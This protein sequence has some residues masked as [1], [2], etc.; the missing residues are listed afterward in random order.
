[1]QVAPFLTNNETV[2]QTLLDRGIRF[3]TPTQF[4][5]L[6]YPNWVIIPEPHTG[7]IGK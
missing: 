2:L 3:E 1:M 5:I 6:I 7:M 4:H